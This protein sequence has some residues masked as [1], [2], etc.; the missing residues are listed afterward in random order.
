[1]PAETRYFRSD[2]HT[3]NGVSAYIL[4]TSESATLAELWIAQGSTVYVGIRVSV[5]HADGSE[6]RLDTQASAVVPMSAP[7]AATTTTLSAGY[8]IVNDVALTPTDAIKV[9]VY[10]DIKTPPAALLATFITGQLGASKL[11]AANWTVY[12]RLRATAKVGTTSNF[13]FRFGVSGDDS[14]ITNFTW[15][16]YAPPPASKFTF[17]KTPISMIYIG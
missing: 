1:M 8:S 3:V 14:Y 11:N 6:T 17:L 16:P 13:Y 2:S 4:G 9:E 7:A 5:I 15:T 12:Y 10:G